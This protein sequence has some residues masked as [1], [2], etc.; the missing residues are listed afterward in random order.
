MQSADNACLIFKKLAVTRA[1]GNP[2]TTC[3]LAF[4]WIP[5]AGYCVYDDLG[6]ISTNFTAHRPNPAFQV[7]SQVVN[8]YTP[9]AVKRHAASRHVAYLLY[10]L[11]RNVNK[12]GPAFSQHAS[13]SWAT[14]ITAI[15]RR[16]T[17][18]RLLLTGAMRV[19]YH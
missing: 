3:P 12:P 14:T 13:Q 10:Y 17:R 8:R 9:R 16:T 15:R 4:D 1:G 18:D 19:N 7:T 2:M 5:D 11:D 6:H